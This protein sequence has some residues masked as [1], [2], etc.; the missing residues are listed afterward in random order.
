M[1]KWYHPGV[2]QGELR[3]QQGGTTQ[4]ASHRQWRFALRSTLVKLGAFP[5]ITMDLKEYADPQ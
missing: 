4:T 1:F 5:M 3:K 2:V